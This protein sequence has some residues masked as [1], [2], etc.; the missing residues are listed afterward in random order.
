MGA[1]VDLPPPGDISLLEIYRRMVLVRALER[2]RHQLWLERRLSGE[3]HLALGQEATSVGLASS[4]R[5]EDWLWVSRRGLALRVARGLPPE[6]AL[7]GEAPASEPP[8]GLSQATPAGDL[9]VAVGAALGMRLREERR[10]CLAEFGDG[11]AGEGLFHESLNLAALWRAP[12]VFACVN[13][14]YAGDRPY[15]MAHPVESVTARAAA[16]GIAAERVDG[17]DAQAVLAATQSAVDRAREGAGPGLVE[18]VTYRTSPHVFRDP[19]AAEER[20][21]REEVDFWR[22]RDPLRRFRAVLVRRH[23]AHAE[24]L[25]VIA[26]AACAE[27]EQAVRRRFGP[28]GASSGAGRALLPVAAPTL[29]WR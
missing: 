6:E 23:Q 15:E 17:Q 13:N 7:A 20:R 9:A 22:N 12:I 26:A 25:D 8:A 21:S 18:C 27:V 10:I 24:T 14:Q 5:P 29:P 16:Y 28:A 11:A 1:R 19:A 4:L 3:L 2:V